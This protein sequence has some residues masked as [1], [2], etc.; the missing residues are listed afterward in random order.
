MQQAAGAGQ[1]DDRRPNTKAYMYKKLK[2]E[3]GHKSRWQKE[4]QKQMG[5]VRGRGEYM[6]V[7]ERLKARLQARQW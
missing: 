1:T 2:N 7:A 6:R 4:I 3:T 5:D